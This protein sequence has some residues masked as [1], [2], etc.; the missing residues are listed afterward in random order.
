MYVYMNTMHANRIIN[1]INSVWIVAKFESCKQE[2]I[3]QSQ[4]SVQHIKLLIFFFEMIEEYRTI[5]VKLS[6]TRVIFR[7]YFRKKKKMMCWVYFTIEIS[8][9]RLIWINALVKKLIKINAH[10]REGEILSYHDIILR[11][12]RA[13]A[14]D[15]R[16]RG[17]KRKIRERRGRG[18]KKRVNA[19]GYT[20]VTMLIKARGGYYYKLHYARKRTNTNN[21]KTLLPKNEAQLSKP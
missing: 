17:L 12:V 10:E 13:P 14:G 19:N 3:I 6:F 11:E 2:R 20:K 15:K 4:I 16:Y 21:A 1:T 9:E 7:F 18:K 5:I 8:F